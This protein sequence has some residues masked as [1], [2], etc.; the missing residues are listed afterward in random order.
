MFGRMLVRYESNS[1]TSLTDLNWTVMN[2]EDLVSDPYGLVTVGAG[3]KFEPIVNGY[4]YVHA[5][6]MTASASWAVGER[7]ILSVYIDGAEE[8]RL[9]RWNPEAAIS[10]YVFV[11]GGNL[12]YIAIGS[13]LDIR[14]YQNSGGAL[15]TYTSAVY[16]KVSI[17]H[18]GY[19]V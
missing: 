6:L 11:G 7:V 19:Y 14:V 18:A 16:N 13:D 1:S 8:A 9:D 5:T 2:Y 17:F 3:W 10:D 4:Y 12:V 15:G